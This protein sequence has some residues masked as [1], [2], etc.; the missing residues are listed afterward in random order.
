MMDQL[1]ITRLRPGAGS[2]DPETYNEENA[3]RY[4]DTI[5]DVLTMKDGTKVTRPDEW[6]KRR[7]E[8]IEEFAREIFGRIPENVPS[9]TW[10]VTATTEGKS[11][12]IPT[13]TKTLV[14]HVDNNAYPQI[15]VD[16]QASFTVPAH[17]TEPVPLM[18]AFGGRFNGRFG[19]GGRFGRPRSGVP[20]T[21]QAIAK[22]WG[23]GYIDPSSIQ[24]DNAKGLR[25][26][27]IGLTN[28]GETRKP[29]DWG[30]LRAW[31]WGVS[32]LI[33]YFEAHPDSKVDPKRIG[34]EGLSRYG[35]AALVTQAFD[36]RVA[37]GLIASS[38][39]GGAKLHRHIFGEAVE[40]LAGGEFYWMGGNFLKY[41]V[42]EGKLGAKTAADLPIDS[43]EL[44][45]LCAPRPCFISYG[46]IEGGDPKWVDARGSFM[47]GILAGP[48]YRLLGKDDFGTPGDYLSDP[49]PPV[50][51]LIGGELA[52]RQ[53]SGG[54]DATPNWPSFFMWVGNYI[55]AL[56][57]VPAPLPAN[58]KTSAEAS[59]SAPTSANTAI[60]R[61]DPLSKIAHEQLLNKA[62]QRHID[63]YFLGDSI[64]RRW[65]CSDPQYSALLENWK[66][67]LF[68]WNA[69]NFGWG[70]D[71]TQN[72][73]W[74]LKEGELD[75][76]QPK[77]I[78][79]L[80]GT[81]NISVE[82][83]GDKAADDISAGIE[84]IVEVCR[85][86]APEATIIVTS[87]FPRDDKTGFMP[88]I[89]RINQNIAKLG[90]GKRIRILNVN[91]SL[92]N[93][94][95]KLLKGMMGDGLHP[96]QQGY[97]VWADGLK[98]ILT[99]LLGPP[100]KT[101]LAPPPTGIPSPS[102]TPN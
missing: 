93:K 91:G 36:E 25:E 37:V 74:R 29:E 56:P 57:S 76:V 44:I 11:G 8:L 51:K 45:A 42:A 47:A 48:V 54:H 72:I 96:T 98:P 26:G 86:K 4:K 49:M 21:E 50:G 79:L 3:N 63:V 6:P 95:G 34:I 80:A 2:S 39:E 16:I 97:Q 68:G 52:W 10:E 23:Y 77:V 22:G 87:V 84:A 92:T 28:K 70:G 94:D 27:I 75:G 81:N 35:K 100:A 78:V 66:A 62:K 46:S 82:S 69:G 15:A 32:R 19:G 60:P 65:G 17:T 12:D 64:T 85:Q 31:Q 38:G 14:G 24:P 7:A 33:D 90:D 53:H 9:V 73:L 43:H 59:A 40:N 58:R 101:D 99:E 89:E 13:I 20:W 67:N 41:A 102:P 83:L 55:K 18:V 88:T 71:T 5:P 1:G 30:A 61:T